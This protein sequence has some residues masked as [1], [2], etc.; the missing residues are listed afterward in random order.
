M[1]DPNISEED[2][3][4]FLRLYKKH[5]SKDITRAEAL[6]IALQIKK[7]VYQHYSK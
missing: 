6:K 7:I 4:E 3:D 2:L 1:F 5:F